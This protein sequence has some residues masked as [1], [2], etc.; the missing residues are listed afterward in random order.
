MCIRDSLVDVAAGRKRADLVL[1]NA[2]YIN[3][4]SNDL[5]LGDG[6]VALAQL[7]GKRC[8]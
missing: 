7:V 8:V 3:V 5:A 6:D 2:T 4:F 1:K